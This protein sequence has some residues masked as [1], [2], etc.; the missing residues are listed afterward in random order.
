MGRVFAGMPDP[1]EPGLRIGLDFDAGLRGDTY[2][3]ELELGVE[4]L[5]KFLGQFLVR[6]KELLLSLALVV[7]KDPPAGLIW[8]LS[9][10]HTHH[11]TFF[12]RP[13]PRFIVVSPSSS[14]LQGPLD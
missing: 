3:P 7:D 5:S 10:S 6:S 13:H 4:P 8:T 14:K 2:A 1:F 11:A 9:N 12:D